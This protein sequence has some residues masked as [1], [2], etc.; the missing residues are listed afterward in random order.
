[1]LQAAIDLNWADISC[2][3]VH[4]QVSQQLYFTA[5]PFTFLNLWSIC[6]S[7]VKHELHVCRY[8][9]V[10]ASTRALSATSFVDSSPFY[11]FSN[12]Y[13]CLRFSSYLRKSY[14]LLTSSFFLVRFFYSFI[15]N[16][17]STCISTTSFFDCKWKGSTRLHVWTH[18]HPWQKRSI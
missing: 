2:S 6:R 18:G 5:V 7:A 11:L 16:L 4:H 12:Y 14:T 13:E 15:Q 17:L 9:S 1:M 8:L 10:W 3:K